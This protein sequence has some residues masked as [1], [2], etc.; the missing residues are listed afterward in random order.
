MTNCKWWR[1]PECLGKTYAK[2]KSLATFSHAPTV[3]RHNPSEITKGNV[4]LIVDLKVLSYVQ[5]SNT[6][7]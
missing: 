3:Q 4:S 1:K 2:P 6:S 5:I 7:Y